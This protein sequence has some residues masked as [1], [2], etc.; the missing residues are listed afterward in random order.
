MDTKTRLLTDAEIDFVAGAGYYKPCY[1]PPS[2]KVVERKKE[3]CEPVRK[4]KCE[5]RPKRCYGGG[6]MTPPPV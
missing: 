4:V 1:P 5:P 3:H 2:C 6:G